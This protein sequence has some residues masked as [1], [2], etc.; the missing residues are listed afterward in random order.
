[1]VW[2]FIMVLAIIIDILKGKTLRVSCRD[3]WRA[4]LHGIL[5]PTMLVLTADFLTPS[6]SELSQGEV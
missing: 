3:Q 5:F 2:I 6:Y 4:T 1:M